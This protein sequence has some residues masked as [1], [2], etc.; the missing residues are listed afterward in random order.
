M[1]FNN[2]ATG[3]E[4]EDQGAA[5]DPGPGYGG[6]VQ[7]ECRPALSEKAQE[8]FRSKPRVLQEYYRAELEMT[9]IRKQELEGNQK[10]ERMN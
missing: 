1:F 3:A 6:Q 2:K 5:A 7:G 4:Q 9:Q 8:E 10:T